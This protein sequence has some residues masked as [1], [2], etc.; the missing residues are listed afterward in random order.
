MKNLKRA[1]GILMFVL[2]FPL[3][4]IIVNSTV[5]ITDLPK[6][7]LPATNFHALLFGFIVDL[8]VA[9]FASFVFTAIFLIEGKNP[10]K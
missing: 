2:L 10:F 1:L 3:V 8:L 5:G 4:F 7:F 9:V 6:P